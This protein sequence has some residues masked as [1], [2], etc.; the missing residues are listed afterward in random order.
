MAY[1][2]ISITGYIDDRKPTIGT[3][4]PSGG[5]AIEIRVDLDLIQTSAQ[6]FAALDLVRSLAIENRFPLG[7]V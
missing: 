4:Q 3:A 5:T 1:K 7:S 6:F 2:S